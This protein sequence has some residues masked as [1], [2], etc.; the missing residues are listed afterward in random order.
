MERIEDMAARL[1]SENIQLKAEREGH[2]V[3]LKQK[4]MR[5][6]KY[7][8]ALVT[9]A[10]IGESRVAEVARKALGLE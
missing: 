4:E 8:Q 5:I 2:L 1:Q 7:R 10:D 6:Q 9:C 3:A